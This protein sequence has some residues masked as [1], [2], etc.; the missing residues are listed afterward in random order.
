MPSGLDEPEP[1]VKAGPAARRMARKAPGDMR[2]PD[3]KRVKLP[4]PSIAALG[5]SG[6]M[7]LSMSKPGA[8]ASSASAVAALTASHAGSD[9]GGFGVGGGGGAASCAGTERASV[10]TAAKGASSSSYLDFQKAIS[11]VLKKPALNGARRHLAT[12]SGDSRAYNKLE[13]EM[14]CFEHCLNL[15]PDK[16]LNASVAQIQKDLG[17]AYRLCLGTS[18][19]ADLLDIYWRTPGGA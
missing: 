8:H 10:T 15:S 4:A 2:P 16:L 3:A 11:G 1:D 6:T 14:Q 17:E 7:Q 5:S 12:L 13:K 18:W 19:G 9:A